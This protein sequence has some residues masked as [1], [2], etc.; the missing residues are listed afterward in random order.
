MHFIQG[1]SSTSLFRKLFGIVWLTIAINRWRSDRERVLRQVRSSCPR[2]M[3]TSFSHYVLISLGSMNRLP[4]FKSPLMTCITHFWQTQRSNHP[5]GIS[6]V[7]KLGFG[8]SSVIP[9]IFVFKW[10]LLTFFLT[11]PRIHSP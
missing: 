6:R 7:D 5:T 9:L 10:V 3:A 2:A 1:G 11:C 8:S 4:H